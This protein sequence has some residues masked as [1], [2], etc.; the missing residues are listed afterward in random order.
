MGT[1][2]GAVA[3]ARAGFKGLDGRE[4]SFNFQVGSG[5]MERNEGDRVGE[6]CSR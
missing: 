1:I 2:A 6:L 4:L 3:Y 5:G